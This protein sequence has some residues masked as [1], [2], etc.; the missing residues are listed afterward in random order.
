MTSLSRAP[1]TVV[2]KK[3]L[4]ASRSPSPRVKRPIGF[5]YLRTIRTGSR[6]LSLERGTL[7]P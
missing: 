1:F 5:L 3:T 7:P 6:A 2:V 4:K